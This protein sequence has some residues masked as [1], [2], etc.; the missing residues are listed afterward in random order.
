ML[1]ARQGTFCETVRFLFSPMFF[2]VLKLYSFLCS[3][4]MSDPDTDIQ[5]HTVKITAHLTFYTAIPGNTGPSGAKSK[6]KTKQ[7]KE[8]KAK[9][10]S[11]SFESGLEN[12]LQLL[13]TILAKH[14]EEKYNVTDRMTYGIKV[15]L[16]SVK[17]TLSTSINSISDIPCRKGDALDIN[18]FA[19]YQ[20]LVKN[21]IEGMP[22]KMNIYID[23]ADIQ[24]RWS[25]V[26]AIL[27]FPTQM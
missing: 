11:H 20:D 2:N 21:I 18:N 23:M 10:F 1:E 27:I 22:S 19:E 17:Y 14:G 15:Q 7:K 24:K 16:P 3:F 6:N 25:G 12:Y 13:K 8:T 9:E 26:C 4:R 5:A